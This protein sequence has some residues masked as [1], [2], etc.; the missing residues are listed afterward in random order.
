MKALDEGKVK[1]RLKISI[2]TNLHYDGKHHPN[3]K[4]SCKEMILL[5]VLILCPSL[6]HAPKNFCN[7]DKLYE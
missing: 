7:T 3:R 4:K 5:T 2:G 1:T 6:D